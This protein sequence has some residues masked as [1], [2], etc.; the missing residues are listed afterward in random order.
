M[1]TTLLVITTIH[2]AITFTAGACA[3]FALGYLAGWPTAEQL[4]AELADAVWQLAHDPL[5]G[6][7][8][9]RG[10]RTAHTALAT[11]DPSQP[12]IAVLLDIDDFKEIND[13]FGHDTGD[14]L[15]TVIANR[16]EPLVAAYGGSLARHSGD[17]YAA[18]LPARRYGIFEIGERIKAA[19]SAPIQLH[20]Q[21]G[22][23]TVLTASI[24]IAFAD[25]TEPLQAALH[26]ADTAMYH[27]KTQ[28]GNQHILHTPGMTMP[29]PK[30][31]RGPRLRD[32]R[33]DHSGSD[34]A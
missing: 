22:P 11:S 28:G 29:D 27:A 33:H 18:I 13:E 25:S 32:R 10:L 17:E 5:T 4:R 3:G 24:G 1:F 23:E 30:H 8:N 21:D 20:G 19:I 26:R 2:T 9:R 7:Y 14:E 12:I 34:A 15:L 16:L 6:L 31:R